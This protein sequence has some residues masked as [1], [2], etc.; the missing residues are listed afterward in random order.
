MTKIEGE[1]PIA[2][3]DSCILHSAALRDFLLCQAAAGLFRPRWSEDIHEE[4]MRTLLERRPNLSL[5]KLERTRK[6]MEEKFPAGL[7][8]DYQWIIPS[9]VLRDE[10]DK[11]VLAVAIAAN[12]ELIVTKN[13]KDFPAS[14]LAPHRIWAIDPDDFAIMLLERE[15]EMVVTAIHEQRIGLKNPP[16]N[17]EDFLKTLKEEGMKK[18]P[19]RLK[20]FAPRL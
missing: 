4:W 11:H 9:L 12:A 7:V 8:T 15:Q 18:L 3:L 5:Q 17:V 20:Q 19:G 14:A 13:L 1:G 2:V 10:K 6:R 16:K